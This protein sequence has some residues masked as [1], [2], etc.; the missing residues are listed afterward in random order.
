MLLLAPYLG[1]DEVLREI[2]RA[3]GLA[4]WTPEGGGPDDD[5]DLWR[6]LQSVTRETAG[7]PE[8]FLGVGDQDGHRTVDPHPLAEAIPSDHRLH[9][10]GGH[11]WGPWKVLWD[12]FLDR[13]DFRTRCSSGDGSAA[14]R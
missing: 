5:R 8:I 13:S 12:E 1:R 7:S 3:G 9:T 11:D 4:H 14:A 2:N 6:Y 10:P